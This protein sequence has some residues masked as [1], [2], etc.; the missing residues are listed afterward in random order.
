MAVVY[1][2]TQEPFVQALPD[3]PVAEPL[4]TGDDLLA[5]GDIG[6]CELIDGRIVMM[7]PTGGIHGEIEITLGAALRYFVKDRKLGRVFSGEVG[8]YIRRNPDRVR[9]AD[10]A[11]ISRQRLPRL[12][13]GFLTAAPE[14]VVEVMSPDDRWNDVRRKVEEY[15]SIGV[16][17]VWVVEPD[18]QKV[19]IFRSSTELTEL[20]IGD[21]L[22]GE[23]VL[24]GFALPLTDLFEED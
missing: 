9:G 19:L 3:T 4:L 12:T 11:F 15:F 10:V 13:P 5:M 20:R 8:I 1:A 2:P 16:E 14:L 18:D 21:T 7:S 23:G 24:A 22:Q 17:R 6:R